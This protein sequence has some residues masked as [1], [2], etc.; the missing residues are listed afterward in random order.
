MRPKLTKISFEASRWS[1]VVGVALLGYCA[2]VLVL[3]WRKGVLDGRIPVRWPNHWS[4]HGPWRHYYVG[5]GLIEEA[6]AMSF[7]AGIAAVLS[8]VIKSSE[9]AGVLLGVCVVVFFVVSVAWLRLIE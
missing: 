4:N 3:L 9:R 7:L 8:L 6:M 5:R 1:F 2:V